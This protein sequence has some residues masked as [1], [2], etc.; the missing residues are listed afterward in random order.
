[1][2]VSKGNIVYL[3]DYSE[4]PNGGSIQNKRRPYLIVSNDRQ[5]RNS[6]VIQAVPLTTKHKRKDLPYHVLVNEKSMAL[7]EQVTSIRKDNIQTIEGTI[8][9]DAKHKVAEGLKALFTF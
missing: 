1:M 6:P 2:R 3:N 5:N 8:T 4:L 9:E 7:T